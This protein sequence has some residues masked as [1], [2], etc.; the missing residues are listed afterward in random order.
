MNEESNGVP[1]ISPPGD[2]S[3]CVG[4]PPAGVVG[5]LQVLGRDDI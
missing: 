2:S 1:P 3:H 5:R 4:A